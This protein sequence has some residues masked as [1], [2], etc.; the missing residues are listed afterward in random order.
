MSI[1]QDEANFAAD[2]GGDL[3]QILCGPA[4]TVYLVVQRLPSHTEVLGKLDLFLILVRKYCLY[5]IRS[6]H[7]NL[8]FRDI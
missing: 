4:V 8:S 5:L 2:E 6:R 1:R 7:C 3:C